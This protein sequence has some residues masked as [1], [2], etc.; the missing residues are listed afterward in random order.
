[1]RRLPIYILIDVSGS[2]NGEP[3]QAV[4]VG[5]EAM[6]ASLKSNPYALDTVW[7][8]L[9]SFGD[10]A[11][12]LVSLT[13]L[14]KFALPTIV[15]PKTAQ[16]NLGKGLQLLCEQYDKEVVKTTS[17]AKGDWRPLLV[18]LTD[19]A[20]TDVGLYRQMS[21]RIRQNYNFARV[22]C[23]AAGKKAR[24]EPLKMLTSEIVA[25][26]QMDESS[27]KTFWVW[28]T[29]T[30]SRSSQ[31]PTADASDVPAPPPPSLGLV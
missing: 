8:S 13:E 15:V 17:T 24:L 22:I 14:E 20:P 29:N 26:E 21:E 5:L 7:L 12:P 10:E 18:V 27:F 31:M 23:C 30:I 2:M 25:L 28:V 3:I 6:L 4:Q 16:T 1:M 9:I 11:Q 19:G